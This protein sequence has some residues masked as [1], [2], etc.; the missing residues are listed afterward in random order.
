MGSIVGEAI[1]NE[2]LGNLGKQIRPNITKIAIKHGLSPKYA[3]SGQVQKTKAYKRVVKPVA[4]R[5]EKERE[6]IT[7]AME[8]TD[9]DEVEYRDLAKVLDTLTQN[10]QLL[11][12]GATANIA[13]QILVRFLDAKD[14]DNKYT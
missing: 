6:R 1:A 14:P 4:M 2:V 7:K 9:L 11:G 13:N 5:W 12:G 3:N 10:I 8:Q